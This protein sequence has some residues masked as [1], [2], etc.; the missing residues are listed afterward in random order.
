MC[1]MKNEVTLSI[2]VPVYNAQRYLERCIESLIQQNVEHY[3]II[4]VDDGSKDESLTICQKYERL[5]DHIKVFHQKNAGANAARK[6]GLAIAKGIYIGFID[7]DDWIDE[8]MFAQLL[9]YSKDKQVDIIS[10]GLIMH[11]KSRDAVWADTIE[12]G[13]YEGKK[14]E[15]LY[16][17][18]LC[19]KHFYKF[20]I[21]PNLC[22]K[23]IKRDILIQAFENIDEKIVYGEDA[24]IVYP[25]CLNATQIFS[26]NEC[27]Y[28]YNV[29]E[30]SASFKIDYY[31][32][33]SQHRLYQYLQKCFKQSEF[34]EE[35]E[36]QLKYYITMLELRVFKHIYGITLD[37]PGEYVLPTERFTGK[38]IILYGAGKV[39]QSYYKQLLSKGYEIVAWTDSNWE[40]CK[41]QFSEIVAPKSILKMEYTDILVAVL[42]ENV[43]EQIK[44]QLCELGV[45]KDKIVWHRTYRPSVIE[46]IISW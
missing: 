30:E 42:N 17:V 29:N 19:N 46:Q 20:G 18:M 44:V 9:S 25:A 16:K 36:R 33:E 39:G 14:L 31:Q 6:S 34:Y 11:E 41:E 13:Y 15:E 23:L 32:Y 5:N 27:F 35:L 40:K 43:F 1:D 21:I 45:K 26:T 4:L 37:C 3:E 22:G 10:S 28:H 12:S 38:K 2:I 8:N 7:S 24:A